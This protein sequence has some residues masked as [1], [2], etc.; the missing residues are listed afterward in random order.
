MATSSITESDLMPSLLDLALIN[1]PSLSSLYVFKIR[2]G[3]FFSI[4]G[5]IVLACKMVAPK[6]ANSFASAYDRFA[7]FFASGT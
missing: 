2:S 7:S 5:I 4:K 3:M 1:V 6:F